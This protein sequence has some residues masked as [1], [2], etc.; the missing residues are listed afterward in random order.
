MK[1]AALWWW[2]A[3]AAILGIVFAILAHIAGGHLSWARP[4]A[5][6][7]LAMP[8]AGVI[9][10][11]G[12]RRVRI[13]TLSFSRV[14][15]AAAVTASGA[16][17]LL[18]LPAVLRA[19][20]M[21]LF[22]LAVARPQARGA[23]TTFESGIDVML[24]LD[25]SESMAGTDLRPTR[26]DAG[27]R[28]LVGFLSAHRGDRVGL[29]AFAE[30]AVVQCPLTTDDDALIAIARDLVIGDIPE[31]GTAIGD[32]VGL[33]LASLSRAGP[34]DKAIL[35]ISDGDSNKTTFMSP[36]EAEKL[37][38][39][40]G[41][42]VFAVLVGDGAGMDVDASLL[43]SMAA[44]TG[45]G[46]FRAGDDEALAAAF[47][48]VRAALDKVR[49]PVTTKVTAREL[50]GWLAWPGAILLGLEL[51]LGMTRLRRFP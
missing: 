27:R 31:R 26:L 33:A 19:I 2:A 15:E 12:R 6:A 40:L 3:G 10:G 45:G 42:R 8:A 5:F 46:F 25:V 32:A 9:A 48:R 18:P 43:S 34:G 29:I 36:G 35:L 28:T 51:F 21:V 17:H 16:A 50:Y 37:A 41:V 13:A 14:A 30:V 39:S 24:A 38:R 44:A 47:S 4:W 11:A 22:A 7:L 49:H 1:S 20:A 23:H